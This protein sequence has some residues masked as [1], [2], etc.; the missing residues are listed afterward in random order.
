MLNKGNE[1]RTI[2]RIPNVII[3]LCDARDYNLE[4]KYIKMWTST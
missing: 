4:D 2:P 1:N 3:S